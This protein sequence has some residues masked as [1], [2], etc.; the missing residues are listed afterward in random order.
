[1]VLDKKKTKQIYEDFEREVYEISLKLDKMVEFFDVDVSYHPVHKIEDQAND[2]PD[3]QI[4]FRVDNKQYLIVVECKHHSD[5]SGNIMKDLEGFVHKL[6]KIRRECKDTEY[7]VKPIFLVWIESDESIPVA[8]QREAT[9]FGIP[10]YERL[11]IDQLSEAMDALSPGVAF[12]EFLHSYCGIDVSFAPSSL[13]FRCL[14]NQNFEKPTFT[15]SMLAS[16][17]VRIAYVNRANVNKRDLAEAYQ[18][19]VKKKR[20]GDIAKFIMEQ[21]R[22]SEIE[23]FPN[24]IVVNL[25]TYNFTPDE[26]NPNFGTLEIPNS[27][28]GLVISARARYGPRLL[29]CLPNSSTT[30]A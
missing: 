27:Y 8:V 6:D 18:R 20:L 7:I 25:H 9:K 30:E 19:A 10:C 23:V 17:L 11:L 26:D 16:D 1:M 21:E 28:N 5:A 4:H 24:N 14:K 22:K 3:Y 15:F 13:S 29:N 2:V 12:L